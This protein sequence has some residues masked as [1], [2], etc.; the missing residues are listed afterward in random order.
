MGTLLGEA[1]GWKRKEKVR[2]RNF[3]NY[4]GTWDVISST[5]EL[6]VFW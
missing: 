6:H 1:E 3:K 4:T 2:K 5:G